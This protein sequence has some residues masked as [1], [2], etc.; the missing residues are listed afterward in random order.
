[1]S[2]KKLRIFLA[3]QLTV[4]LC[5]LMTTDTLAVSPKPVKE[6][7]VTAKENKKNTASKVIR[8]GVETEINQPKARFDLSQGFSSIAAK[9]IPGVVNVST[10]QVIEGRDRANMPQFAPGSP[11]DEFFK[12]FFDQMDKPRRVQSLGSGFIIKVDHKQ[13]KK[14]VAY[15]VTNYHVIV[16]AKKI[17]VIT[18]DN[19]EFEAVLHG[20]DDRTDLAVLKVDLGSVPEEKL[21]M[22]ALEWGDSHKAL[23]GNWVLAFGNPFGLGGTV[24]AGIL[25][26][27]SRDINLRP[28]ARSRVSEY[29]D[30]FMQHD[31]PIN[32]G[33]SGGP[34]V[35][36]NG[37][38]IGINTAI[39]S[40][41][42][43]N[44]GIG[45]AIPAALASDT[46]NQLIELGRTK[47]GWLGVLA[48]GVSDD[49]AESYGLGAA[50]G[51]IIANVTPKGPAA[52]AGIEPGDII[53]QLDGKNI[54]E[55]NKLSRVVGETDVGKAVKVK[56]WRK[57]KELTVSVKLGEFETAATALGSEA[58][59]G[60]Q[61]PSNEPIEILG[62]KLSGMT[63][64]LSQQFQ[65]S[66]NV[67]GVVV[68]NIASDSAVS[69][70]GL[71]PGD[72]ISEANQISVKT[73]KDFVE[74]IERA[75]KN[76][77]KNITLLVNRRSDMFYITIKLEDDLKG[78]S[79]IN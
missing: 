45:F 14:G 28:N 48:Q 24:T 77:R 3:L 1:M 8:P 64:L 66:E 58:K 47:R 29:V 55:K 2:Y 56:L 40:P 74:Q 37:K 60:T 27:I 68:V 25:S 7:K 31:A 69:S 63:A 17:T 9:V 19:T 6:E 49:M 38:V 36:L 11:L 79:V 59:K 16:D 21:K 34:L 15:I 13:G 39:F 12:D 50:R 46:V 4:G 30:D 75:K 54:N 20:I 65:I 22:I 78:R 57:G 52:T 61:S 5:P 26:S 41:S 72:V 51:A 10:T 76:K 18:H 43:G 71:R 32:M 67:E 44:V 33:S 53:L 42:G 73:P 70:S 23:V 62:L 35:D